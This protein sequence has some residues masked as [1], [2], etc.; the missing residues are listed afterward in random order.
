M[1]FEN[2]ESA[3]ETITLSA[4]RLGEDIFTGKNHIDAISE[5]EGEY[6]D[7]AEDQE[8]KPEDGFIT[9]TGRFVQRDEAGLIAKRAGQLDHLKREWKKDA[10][11]CLDSHRLEDLQPKWLK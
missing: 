5:M 8:C 3:P 10:E 9:S 11:E 4:I 1:K 2:A 6:P 7:W